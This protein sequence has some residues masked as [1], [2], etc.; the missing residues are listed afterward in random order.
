M[1][2]NLKDISFRSLVIKVL[3][4]LVLFYLIIVA[5]SVAITGFIFINLD[6]YK[7]K[8]GDLVYEN[9]G[10]NLTIGSI[11]TK[12][13]KI[14]M[15]ELLIGDITLSNPK[16]SAQT[17]H[18]NQIA[19]A[20]DYSSVW[21]FQPI[22][23]QISVDGTSIVLEYE[24]NGAL[25]VNGIQATD[26]ADQTLE[27]TK[28]LP[29]DLEAWLLRQ[30]N[31]D[32]SNIS[33]AFHDKKN[34]LPE[35][36]FRNI[37]V[38]LDRDMW[39]KHILSATLYG[40][41]KGNDIHAD[42]S[43]QGGKFEKWQKWKNADLKVRAYAK[44]GTLVDQ[45]GKYLPTNMDLES[46]NASTA[47]NASIRDGIVQKVYANFDVNNFKLAL[48]DVDVVNFPRLGGTLNID[49]LDKS[50]YIIKAK[51][52]EASTSSGALFNN[53]QINGEYL[54]GKSGHLELS[55]TNLLALNNL[56]SLFNDT[57]GIVLHG[58]V[59]NVLFTWG[60]FLT[61]PDKYEF[62][63]GFDKIS[64]QSNH[65]ALPSLSNI[66]GHVSLNQNSGSVTLNLDDSVL[67]YDHVFLIPYEFKSL[68]TKIDW[69]VT[70]S[71]V[72]NVVMNKTNLETKDFKAVAE[73]KFVYNP[74]NPENP[75]YIDMTAHVDK[76]LTSKVGD[77]LPK[78]IPM[79]VHAWLNM[80]LIGGYGESAD[81]ILRGPLGN[82]PF[83]DGS[84]L[85]YITANIDNAKLQYVKNWPTLDNIYGQF[86]LKN[87]NI[88]IKADRALVNKNHLDSTVVVI[89]DYSN[90]NG[91][92]LTADG[93]AHGST[94]NFM[95]Y[96]KKTP[97]NE[98]IGRFPEKVDAKGDGKLAIYLKVPFKEPKKTE[99]K[100]TYTFLNNDLK[101]DLPIPE[102]YNVDGVLGFNQ[103][104]VNSNGLNAVAFNSAAKIY[105]DTN[106]A[107]K[108]H[109]RVDA[110]EL[111]YVEISK[112]Y[113]PFLSSLIEGR[114]PTTVDFVIGKKGIDSLVANSS[115]VGVSVNAPAPIG[116]ESSEIRPI[117]LTM[118]PDGASTVI[119]DWSYGE[120]MHGQQ[121][122][123]G[124]SVNSKGQIAVGDVDYLNNPDPSSIM[125]I[126]ANVPEVNIEQ[127]IA[128]VNRVV[129]NAKAYKIALESIPDSNPSKK[130]HHNVMP[131]QIQVN[132][133]HIGLGKSDLG[134]GTANIIVEN[135]QTFFNLYTPVTSGVGTYNY[136]QNKVKLSL[137]KYMLYKKLP[138]TLKSP[139]S[140]VP[141]NFVNGSS[142]SAKIKIPDIDLNINNLFYQNHN[143]G[144]VSATLHQDEDNLYLKDGILTSSDANV[145]FSG[146]NYCFGCD[147]G[148]SYVNFIAN[149][150]VSNLGNLIYNLDFGRVLSN[151]RG[152]ANAT[153]QWNGGFQDFKILQTVGSFKG[154]F[155]SG[156]FLK[157]DPGFFGT[158][159]SII[160]LQGIFEFGSGDVGDIFK[161]GFFFNSLDMDIDILTSRV[162]LKHVE[163]VGPMAQVNSI[164]ILD[165]ANNTIDAN[166]SVTPHV[167]FAVALVAGIATLNPIVGLAVYGAELLSDSVQNKLFT[168]RY[169]VKGDLK[170]PTVNKT[171]T[172]DTIIKNLNS[173]VG[174][175]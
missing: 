101:L 6:S 15:P 175:D 9:T 57:N 173:T 161:K 38:S 94:A 32:L 113:L 4:Y 39:S 150:N 95:D 29:F 116:T 56:L 27:N 149:A 54:I 151:G 87:T 118:R 98:I 124:K 110:P 84:G 136:A 48:A 72:V 97:V 16:N 23:N 19:L 44:N 96:L 81:M 49:L 14:Y 55:N 119:L 53:A 152:T 66:S 41:V 143:L 168:F 18:V 45:L 166:L 35:V 137:D 59:K 50:K 21:N 12:L 17:S 106:S 153:L 82:F 83:Q 26:P 52:L 62:S 61:H 25:F 76:V 171:E 33:L 2:L 86:I 157:I 167:G 147:G 78:Q 65:P 154:D 42:L 114:S 99:V 158:I 58:I 104:G 1:R 132:S 142:V 120:S 69:S 174:V 70:E 92:Y 115:T 107:G 90:P 8:I 129:K 13:N 47:V 74:N 68:N 77:Y 20:L 67:N 34:H 170:K 165:F 164:G 127:W 22:F 80:G 112:F 7:Q 40:K 125:T 146:A 105:A 122:I 145:N 108:M 91:V 10:F 131:M 89:P 28:A 144:K 138:A 93:K 11:Q 46:S 140:Y 156:K 85:F 160:N 130:L 5:I 30:K 102:I 75:N 43:W 37:Q 148:D 141:L 51:N 36:K 155:S 162:E 88:T 135:D 100:G 3:A 159:F 172:T 31:I 64:I 73:G 24:S 103:H 133:P 109:F 139:E 128:T 163:M 169:N 134:T 63:A 111:D 123:S 126:N 71:K 79:S 117:K 121:I 60:G